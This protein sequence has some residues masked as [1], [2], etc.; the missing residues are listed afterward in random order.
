MAMAKWPAHYWPSM[1]IFQ[2]C[3]NINRENLYYS[4]V[5]LISIGQLYQTTMWPANQAETIVMTLQYV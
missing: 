5:A 4:I 1:V 2:L 3:V